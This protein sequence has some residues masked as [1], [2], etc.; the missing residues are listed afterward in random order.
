MCQKKTKIVGANNTRC[1]Y[2]HSSNHGFL[3][4]RF[5]LGVGVDM[6]R[7]LWR[8]AVAW[9]GLF[10]YGPPHR[11]HN[12][13]MHGFEKPFLLAAWG[14]EGEDGGG[15]GCRKRCKGG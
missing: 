6:C 13:A 8:D 12:G 15:G 10:R 11:T 7:I 9:N 4:F 5:S 3:R 1:C 2:R 14:G